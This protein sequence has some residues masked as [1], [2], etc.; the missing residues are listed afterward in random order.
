VAPRVC[1]SL[2]DHSFDL[3]GWNFFHLFR[4]AVE[5]FLKPLGNACPVFAMD[6]NL[7]R[8]RG[9]NADFLVRSNRPAEELFHDGPDGLREFTSFSD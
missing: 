2:I 8:R 1:D 9:G 4:T 3:S 6:G 7:S 5:E